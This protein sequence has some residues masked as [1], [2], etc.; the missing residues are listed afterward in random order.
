M[1]EVKT[2]IKS[3]QE[4]LSVCLENNLT[5]AAYRLPNKS[6]PEL[7]VQQQHEIL[8]VENL[9]NITSLNGFLV[10]PFIQSAENPMFLIQPDFYFKGEVSE[11]Q[12]DELIQ[13]NHSDKA[14]S[15]EELPYEVSKDEYLGQIEKIIGS[16]KNNDF[17]KVVLS[18]TKIV[19]NNLTGHIP[20]L[21][22]KLCDRF[23][24]AFIYIFNTPGKLWIG[25]TPEPFAVLNNEVFY[26]SSVAGTKENT[27]KY[28]SIENWGS[29]EILEQQYVTDYINSVLNANHWENITHTGP[30]V[31][32]AGNLLHLRTDFTSVSGP[33]NG[34]LGHLITNL[35]PTPAVCGFPKKEALQIIS[36]VE[37]HNREYY[38]GF[39][40]PVGMG[41]PVT[42]FVNLRCMK[43]AGSNI[44]LYSGGGLT[45]DS[46]PVD[47]WYETEIK[48]STLLSVIREIQ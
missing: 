28:R 12:F 2:S 32:K 17:Q 19:N 11:E 1:R 45:I 14:S 7:I 31:K 23:P 26:T 24:N 13:I 29:K 9:A 35:H 36:E 48:A 15:N 38:S 16:I 18:R 42:L 4:T 47:E 3:I 37:K 43:I 30:Y 8:P 6:K 22:S 33:S 46:H 34:N 40:G 44:V 20:E 39:L 21:L 41:Q 5:F 27:D 10:A 25:A